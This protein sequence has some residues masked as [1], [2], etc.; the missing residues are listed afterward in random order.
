[1]RHDAFSAPPICLRPSRRSTR[2]TPFSTTSPNTRSGRQHSSPHFKGFRTDTFSIVKAE[3]RCDS[4]RMSGLG[5]KCLS[6]GSASCRCRQ[7]GQPDRHRQAGTGSLAVPAVPAAHRAQ[8]GPAGRHHAR[9]KAASGSRWSGAARRQIP[10]FSSIGRDLV[11]HHVGE[12]ALRSQAVGWGQTGTS[13]RRARAG[14]GRGRIPPFPPHTGLATDRPPS[15]ATSP[16]RPGSCTVPIPTS[17]WCSRGF[18]DRGACGICGDRNG[19]RRRASRTSRSPSSCRPWWRS[20]RSAPRRPRRTPGS[21]R[22]SPCPP[23]AVGALW[24]SPT[25]VPLRLAGGAIA[26]FPPHSRPQL[27]GQPPAAT[28][29]LL[30]TCGPMLRLSCSIASTWL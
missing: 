8:H 6:A 16:R 13:G 23:A 10:R 5:Q 12:I 2:V 15:A 4:E 25:P 11:E 19:Q 7:S 29:R 21:T 17:P 27:P 14:H 28:H 22:A 3:S 18:V 9:P 24:R 1:M 20:P 26:P 30:P